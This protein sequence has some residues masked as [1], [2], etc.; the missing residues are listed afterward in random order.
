MI[1]L[2]NPGFRR[3]WISSFFSDI[4]TVTLVMCSGLLVLDIT[5]SA[6]WVGAV[7]GFN[8]AA[9]TVSSFIGGLLADRF[10]SRRHTLVAIAILI[11]LSLIHI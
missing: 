3:L 4:L 8:G 7:F 9:L 5:D 10:Y 11:D 6:F 2:E 1:L